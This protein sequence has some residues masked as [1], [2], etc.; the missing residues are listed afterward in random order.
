M[1]VGELLMSRISYGSAV[2]HIPHASVLIPDEYKKD[3][4]V[5]E[6]VL[7]RELR[8]MTDAFCDELYDAPEFKTRIIAPVSRLVCDMERFRDDKDEPNARKGQGLMYTRTSLGRKL[9]E[10]D[11]ALRAEILYNYYDVHHKQLEQAVE[12]SL[13]EYGRCLIIDCHSFNSSQIVKFD[14]LFSMPDFDIGTDDFHTP[15][16]LAD[17]MFSTV[18][19]LGFKARFNS[20]FGGCITPMKYYMKDRRVLSVMIETNRKLYMDEKTMQKNSSFGKIRAVCHELMHSAVRAADEYF[21]A[22]L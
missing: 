1:S 13:S 8:R 16:I 22:E 11:P 6:R 7:R 15:K 9:R 4:L 12:N 3:F 14:N 10:N 18:R 21:E 19:R 20:P 17:S 2:V 5:S